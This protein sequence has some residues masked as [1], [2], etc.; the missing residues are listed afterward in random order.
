[1][2][3]LGYANAALDSLTASEIAELR[4]TRLQRQIDYCL[5][6]SGFYRDLFRE[7][8]ID[9]NSIRTIDDFRE[10]PIL[11]GKETE[12]L[13]QEQSRLHDG[14]PF[15]RHLCA[16]PEDVVLTATTSGTTGVPTF[17]YTLTRRD[18][19]V[20][21]QAVNHMFDYAGVSMGGRILFA[22]SLGV[23]AT[24]IMIQPIRDGGRLPVDIDV[25]GGAENIIKFADMASPSGAMMT[26]S[27]AQ[28]LIDRVAEG[29]GV[30]RWK[31]DA[32]MVAGEI[33][34]SIPE[35]R[36]KIEDAYGCTVFDW[37]APIGGTLAF[38]CRSD[39]YHG[40]H[41]VT[42]ELDLYPLDVVDPDTRKP[43][44][45]EDGV[46]GELIYTSL[47]RQAN[48]LLR[49]AS[50]DVAR[51]ELSPCPHCGFKGPRVFVV[52]RSDDMLIV[53]G[54][55]VYP[56]TIKTVIQEFQPRLT[57]QFRIVLTERP[58]RV[59]PPL[60]IRVEV[61]GDVP[62]SALPGL[63]EKLQDELSRRARVKPRIIWARPGEIPPAMTKT[64][65]FEVAY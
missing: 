12:R 9:R 43:L 54:A 30:G 25:R 17:T 62:E 36:R 10:L 18:Q 21:S 45:I 63:A 5:G 2:P 52:G 23:Y 15:G 38:S 26:P 56:A 50:G 41:V 27:L 49:F 46:T 29:G 48:P 40:L 31:L 3:K 16:D 55:N 22:H 57:G 35:I 14:H 24:S 60:K 47:F 19:A 64:P 33:A 28:H 61:A 11:M 39:E 4:N 8:G 51:V 13:S 37:M 44:P 65:M 59:E 7:H 20:L 1:M 6:N 34:V 53:K 58:P 32:L 42:P